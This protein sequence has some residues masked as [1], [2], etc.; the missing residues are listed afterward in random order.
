MGKVDKA[1]PR[2][3]R[4]RREDKTRAPREGVKKVKGVKGPPRAPLGENPPR[5]IRKIRKNLQEEKKK[6]LH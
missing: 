1:A 6:K 2:D 4:T 3:K 5:W